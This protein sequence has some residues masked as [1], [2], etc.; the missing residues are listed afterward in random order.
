MV[1]TESAAAELRLARTGAAET[2]TRLA[3][4]VQDL[5]LDQFMAIDGPLRSEIGRLSTM[6]RRAGDS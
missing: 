6:I 5:S 3:A 2:L 1:L 4:M